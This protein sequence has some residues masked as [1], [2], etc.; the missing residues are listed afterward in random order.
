MD[1]NK[2]PG[3]DNIPTEFFQHCWKNPEIMYI[4]HCF[5]VGCL[6]LKRLNYGVITLLQKISGAEKITQYRPICLLRCIYKWITKT[7]TLRLEPYAPKL[8][9]IQQ[10]AFIK[11]RNIMDGSSLYTSL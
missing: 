4:F 7:L 5:H 9:S 3:P 1:V 8:F 6:D 10:N 2:A 11:N